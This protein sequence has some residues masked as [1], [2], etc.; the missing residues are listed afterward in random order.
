VAVACPSDLQYRFAVNWVY[1]G[2]T[3]EY[4]M[5]SITIEL[6][7]DVAFAAQQA[8]L[9]NSSAVTSVLRELVRLRAAEKF[10]HAMTAFTTQPTNDAELSPQDLQ[11]AIHAANRH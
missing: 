1:I 11:N 9:L 10:R 2:Y 4:P 7:D 8:G 3:Q 6:P 5:T